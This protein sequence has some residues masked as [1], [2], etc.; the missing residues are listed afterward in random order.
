MVGFRGT[1]PEDPSVQ[2]LL[3]NLERGLVAGVIFFA[4]NL[5]SPSQVQA[6]TQAFREVKTPVPP[7]LALDQEGGRVQRLGPPNGFKAFPSARHVAKTLS[8]QEAHALYLE[9]AHQTQEAGFNFVF[10]PVVDL[11]SPTSPVIGKLERAYASQ[12]GEI[13][14]Y[15][16]AFVEAHRQKGIRTCLKHFPGHGLAP[17]DTHLGWVDVTETF[18]TEELAP[19]QS[20]LQS[21]HADAVMASHL[22]HKDWDPLF[23]VSLSAE[24][25]PQLL[26]KEM[27]YQGVV[28]TDDLHMGAI[29][30]HFSLETV[31]YQAIKAHNDLLI[32]S[33]NPLAAGKTSAFDPT[34]TLPEYLSTLLAQWLAEDHLSKAAV[35]RAHNRVWA[36]RKAQ[37]AIS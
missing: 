25:M 10:G 37:L 2:Q 34:P 27:G 23:P 5:I 31:L 32:V 4:H 11:H 33:G 35:D 36:L 14:G 15:A 29:G 13:I 20:L 8:L 26:R 6:L 12:A 28:V 3:Q 16:Q 19:F 17:G 18:S 22:F 24:M 1:A 30:Q 7:L 9:M 21:G